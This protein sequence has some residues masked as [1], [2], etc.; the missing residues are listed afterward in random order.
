MGNEDQLSAIGPLTF[1]QDPDVEDIFGKL[2]LQLKDGMHFQER[3][4][5]YQQFYFIK[6]NFASLE[7]YY[8]KFNKVV[9]SF[10]G[11]GSERY[12]FLDFN[13]SDRGTIDGDHRYFLR[14]EYVIVGFMLY[15]I[16]FIDRNFDLTSVQQLQRMILTE[17][18]ELME[19]IYRLLA[20]LRRSNATTMGNDKVKEIIIDALKEFKK[21]GWVVM[22]EDF[23]DVM[24]AFARLNKVYGDYINNL[25]DLLKN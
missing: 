2:D 22:E 19:D 8:L 12:Y 11:E 13:G 24:P 6:K 4:H 5:Q 10:G 7:K 3:E 23:F 20:K 15:K 9:L 14:P 17:Y 25:E 1:Y 16:I 18:E 21:M